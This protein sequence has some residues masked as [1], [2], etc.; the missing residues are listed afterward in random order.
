MT[1][2]NWMLVVGAVALLGLSV[3]LNRDWFAGDIIQ[4]SHRSRPARTG[5]LGRRSRKTPPTMEGIQ[6]L[7]FGFDR[8]VMLTSLKVVL[9]SDIST[10]KYAHAYWHLV[11]ESNSVPVKEFYYGTSIKG[12]HP[13]I[14]GAQPDPLEPGE[15]YR[16]IVEAANF[17][18]EHDFSPVANPA[19]A[20]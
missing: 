16:L 14:K 6:P 18:G 5:F 13:A 19:T 4:I 11:S 8:K 1:K 2:K 10:N 12:M 15:N 17:K 3:Y 9:I 7:A 20:R